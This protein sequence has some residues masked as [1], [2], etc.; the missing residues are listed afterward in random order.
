MSIDHYYPEDEEMEADE[1]VYGFCIDF[2]SED[3]CIA[4]GMDPYDRIS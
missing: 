2:L 4:L 3:D 1:Q